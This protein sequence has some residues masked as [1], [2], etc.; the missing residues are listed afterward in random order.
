MK[1]CRL[2]CVG[3]I[4]AA[5]LPKQTFFFWSSQWQ[6]TQKFQ[7]AYKKSIKPSDFHFYQTIN[8]TVKPNKTIGLMNQCRK[9]VRL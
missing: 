1:A 3:N 4:N 2:V 8:M 6:H 7:Q 5:F 9:C